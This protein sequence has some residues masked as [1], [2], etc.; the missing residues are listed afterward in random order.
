MKPYSGAAL[1]DPWSGGG[2][3]LCFLFQQ[4]ELKFRAKGF[5]GFSAGHLVEAVVV[6]VAPDKH[7]EILGQYS[8]A[9]WRSEGM[10]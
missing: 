8:D 9:K 4:S 7:T 5:S 3:R 1:N 10:F 6:W 2:A